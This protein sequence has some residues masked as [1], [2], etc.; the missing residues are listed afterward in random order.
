MNKETETLY[1]RFWNGSDMPVAFTA[2]NSGVNA[3]IKVIASYL[4]DQASSYE[5]AISDNDWRQKLTEVCNN[6]ERYL[7]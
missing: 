3:A 2:F 1:D 5:E 4:A 7:P 6:H